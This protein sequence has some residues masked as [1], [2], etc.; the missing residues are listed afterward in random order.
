MS[1]G[2]KLFRALLCFEFIGLAHYDIK[3]E[4]VLDA[5]L[6]GRGDIDLRVCFMM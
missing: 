5:V 6:E 3:P 2:L 1:S 4:N